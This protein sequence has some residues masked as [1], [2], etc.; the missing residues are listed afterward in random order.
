MSRSI[1][2][3]LATMVPIGLPA[4]TG[5][6]DSAAA[7]SIRSRLAL[8]VEQ[9]NRGDRAAAGTIWAPN[10]VCW[11]PA[12]PLFGDSAAAVAAGTERATTGLTSTYQLTI[13]D[14]RVFGDLAV[15][16]DIWTETR[17]FPGTSRTSRRTI[18]GS[19]LWHRAGDGEWRI[20]RCVSA[21][22]PWTPVR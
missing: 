3:L 20:E 7:R 12:A 21:P 2:F 13:D 15:V 22:E 17:H 1:I 19:E 5:K 16:H 8:W 18:R 10:P 11:F 4:Q 9:T 14:L 6:A